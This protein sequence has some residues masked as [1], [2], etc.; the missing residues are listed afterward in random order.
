MTVRTRLAGLRRNDSDAV[1]GQSIGTM[2]DEELTSVRQD[3]QTD[4]TVVG[5]GGAGGNTV[6]RMHEEGIK[7]A[8]LVAA[9]TDVQHLVDEVAANT[10]ILIGRKR[11][12]GRGAGS[13]PKIGEEAAQEDIDDIQQSI[14][15]SDMVFVAAGLGG[16]TGSGGAPSSHRPRRKPAHSPFLSS[17]F[18]SPPRVNGAVLTPTLA[19]NDSVRSRTII[20]VRTTACWTM[21]RRCR[22]RTR[23]DLCRVLMRS[24]RDDRRPSR[25][26]STWIRRRSDHGE[27]RRRDDWPRRI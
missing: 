13:V 24:V 20:V 12:G 15:G 5:C 11:T 10:K 17:R 9:N 26:R 7:G 1:A 18:R 14:D 27:R 3:L 25:P 8:K 21:R 4:I 16:G 2:T 22:C 23:Q 19:S 6:N